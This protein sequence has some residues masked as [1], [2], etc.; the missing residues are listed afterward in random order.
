[1]NRSVFTFSSLS[2]AI[3]SSTNA[4]IM[5]TPLQTG[6]YG[7]L[8]DGTYTDFGSS[9]TYLSNSAPITGFK[10][11]DAS[12]GTLT[13]IKFSLTSSVSAEYSFDLYA[14][15]ENIPYGEVGYLSYD[16]YI[17]T[18]V[19]YGPTG[20]SFGYSM[21]YDTGF[22]IS[23]YEENIDVNNYV[24]NND[25]YDVFEYHGHDNAESYGPNTVED[26]QS[27]SNPDFVLSD[28][29]GSPT[30]DVNTLDASFYMEINST[31]F[32]HLD[33]SFDPS[34]VFMSIDV[35]MDGGEATLQYIYDDNLGVIPEPSAVTTLF[36]LLAL[37]GI[38]RRRRR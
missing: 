31:F 8:S 11:F 13:G 3:V 17:D 36:G 37:G 35:L 22:N 6:T 33:T 32:S 18:D 10:K 5:M 12:L 16:N 7:N 1:M 15:D 38:T 27:F 30:E 34:I 29:V 23:Y 28:F 4:A 14:E 2:L 20:S 26:T 25:G 21:V 19:V 24:Y 9:T